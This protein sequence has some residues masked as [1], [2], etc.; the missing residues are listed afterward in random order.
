[1]ERGGIMKAR[2]ADNV[3]GYVVTGEKMIQRNCNRRF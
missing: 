1:M 3:N 2:L